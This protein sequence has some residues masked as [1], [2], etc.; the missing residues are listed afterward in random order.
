MLGRYNAT[1][2][3][4]GQYVTSASDY[5][6][7]T[8]AGTWTYANEVSYPFGFGLSYTTF[9]QTLDSV[10]ISEDKK[11]A[12]VEVTVTNTG[13]TYSGKSVV[14]LYAQAPYI[15]GGVEKSAIQLMDYEKT[16]V[17]EP[18]ESVKVTLYVDMSNLASYDY[19]DAKT[20]ILDAGTYY[21]AIGADSHDALN[22]I[23]AAQGQ[24]GMVG[25]DGS[26]SH[27]L[28]EGAYR[29]QP[30]EDAEEYTGYGTRVAPSFLFA[31]V[32][33]CARADGFAQA[34]FFRAGRGAGSPKVHSKNKST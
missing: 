17:L 1:S 33:I 4:A 28:G 31:A 29:G 14:Q 12:T 30:Y 11:T 26:D 22:N 6:A 13:E 34:R 3:D 10:E 24:S 15:E 32:R 23:L 7:A 5:T 27:T 21:F 18:G 2:A 16:D 25:T 20:Y 19:E 9:S 8:T